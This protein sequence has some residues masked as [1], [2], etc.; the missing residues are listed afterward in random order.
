LTVRT[1]WYSRT[2][3]ERFA[4]LTVEQ[5]E[6]GGGVGT[7]VGVGTVVGV[8]RGVGVAVVASAATPWWIPPPGADAD[9]PWIRPDE[10]ATR[11]RRHAAAA[12]STRTGRQRDPVGRLGGSG[13]TH[14]A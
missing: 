5:A 3:T 10:P 6:K 8:G 1:K 4:E 11:A 7:G 14:V 13:T 9:R 12:A 2:G